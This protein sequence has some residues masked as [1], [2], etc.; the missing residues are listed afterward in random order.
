MHI[1]R[2]LLIGIAL[3]ALVSAACGG[4]NPEPPGVPGEATVADAAPKGVVAPKDIPPS[5]LSSLLPQASDFQRDILADGR[6]TLA[7]YE[8]AQLAQV[9]CLRDAGFTIVGEAK[10]NGLFLYR[11]TVA[12]STDPSVHSKSL[13][14]CKREYTNVID[15]VWAEVSQPMVQGVIRESRTLMAECYRDSGL[16]IDDRPYDSPDPEISEKYRQCVSK[17]QTALDISG[18]TFGVDGDGRPQ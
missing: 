12:A 4:G 18:V 10:L 6:L 7:E 8:S 15:M 14:D 3:A 2:T 17:M 13:G 11:Y 16:S 9:G 5:T 1:F